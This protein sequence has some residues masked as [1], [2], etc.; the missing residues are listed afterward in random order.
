MKRGNSFIDPEIISYLSL[1][2]QL[3][4]TMIIFIVIFLLIGRYVDKL[5]GTNQVFL[6]VGILIGLI[7]GIYTNYKQLRKFYEDK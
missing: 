7:G 2:T 4:L 3:G 6:I 5:L 1:I